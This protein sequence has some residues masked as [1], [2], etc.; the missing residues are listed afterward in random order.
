MKKILDRY[1]KLVFGNDAVFDVQKRVF[2][3]ITH[4]SIIIGT[5][6]GIPNAPAPIDADDSG[7]IA[8]ST[9]TEN[10]EFTLSTDSVSIC[11]YRTLY[12]GIFPKTIN[13]RKRF[14]LKLVK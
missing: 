11:Q 1:K 12:F 4:I 10:I 8:G 9:K 6:G 5:V 2:L 3:L 14:L 7:P 13:Y